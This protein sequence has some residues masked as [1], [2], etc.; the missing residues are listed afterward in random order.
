MNDDDC[1]GEDISQHHKIIFNRILNYDTSEVRR[2]ILVEN[3]VINYSG[4]IDSLVKRLECEINQSGN[5]L[6]IGEKRLEQLLKD[7]NFYLRDVSC[8]LKR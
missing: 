6:S 5:A 8:H 3:T 2:L 7:L 4:G 1:F